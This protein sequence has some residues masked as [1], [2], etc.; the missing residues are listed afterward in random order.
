MKSFIACWALVPAFF[1]LACVPP[2]QGLDKEDD[3]NPYFRKASKYESDGN[4]PAAIREYESALRANPNVAAAHYRIGLLYDK[5]GNP[6]SEIHHF[7]NYLQA[8]PDAHNRDQVDSLIEKAKN[9]FVM[10]IPNSP[11]VNSEEVARMGRENLQLKRAL[12]ET[13][14]V[15]AQLRSQTIQQGAPENTS[16]V[17]PVTEPV[18]P[19]APSLLSVETS[20]NAPALVTTPSVAT[21]PPS[22]HPSIASTN[23]IAETIP[24]NSRTHTIAKGDSLWKISRQYYPEDIAGGVE[25]IK[26]ANPEKTGNVRGLKLGETLIIP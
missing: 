25:K 7:Q 1:I 18:K 12:A 22:N 4:I 21:A 6:I 24:A 3:S 5:L 13:Q 9:D 19:A 10:T 17:A 20:T 8:R 11:A 14:S 16:A 15:L 23:T 2:Q 26:K